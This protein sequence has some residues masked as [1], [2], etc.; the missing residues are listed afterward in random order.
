M[1]HVLAIDFDIAAFGKLVGDLFACH[2]TPDTT[3]LAALPF[4]RWQIGFL[5]DL[6]I[7]RL[8]NVQIGVFIQLQIRFIALLRVGGIA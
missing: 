2:N 3:N 7:R 8:A 1:H 4:Q 5:V 6:Q